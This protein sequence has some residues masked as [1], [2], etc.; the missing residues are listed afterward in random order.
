MTSRLTLNLGL[1]YEYFTPYTEVNNKMANFI[2]DPG[3]P[4]F[5]Q[6]AFAG[7]ANKPRSLLSAATNNWAPRLGFAYRVPGAKDLV[8]RGS[9][10]IFYAQDQGNGITS[11]MTSNPPFFGYG[12]IA[13]ISDQIQPSTA[14]LLSSNASIPRPTP[15][16]PKNFVLKPSATTPLVSWDQQAVTPYVQEWNFTVEKQLPWD[17]VWSTNYVGNVGI[18][19]WGNYNANQPL[20]NGPGSP[21]S[22]RPFAQ[23]TSGAINRFSP[24]DRSNYEGISSRIE[25][26]FSTGVSFLASF[27][28]G[29]A[30]DLQNPAIDL[31]DSSGGGD[32]VQNG[33]D[34]NANRAISD[35]DVPLRFVLSGIWDLP[36]GKGKPFLDHGWGAA[37]AG[38]WE[39][40]G[41]YQVQSGVPFTPV[42][43]FDNANAGTTSRPDRVCSGSLSNPTVQEYFNVSC[44]AT[45]AAYTFGN[46]GRNVLFGPGE[47]NVDFGLHRS[48]QLPVWESAQLEFRAEAFNVFNHPQFNVPAATIGVANAGTIASTSVPNRELQLALRLSF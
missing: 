2:I 25:K 9:Y 20:T 21:N 22:R 11:R 34:L 3:D 44:F 12:G 16:A 18:H 31:V 33:Y 26:R 27:T 32:T 28:Y 17:M 29:R 30:I 37:I 35:G 13:L 24:W 36:F 7:I 40:S 47:N 8:V 10:G 5:G 19:L 1:R 6:L 4:Y 14:F 23:Y 42:L 39:L 38:Q 46:S 45:P 43:S 48:F 41:I 15:V